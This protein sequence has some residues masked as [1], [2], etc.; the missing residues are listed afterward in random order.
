MKPMFDQLRRRLAELI[1]PMKPR[2]RFNQRHATRTNFDTSIDDVFNAVSAA[3]NGDFN[4]MVALG[5]QMLASDGHVRT[6]FAKRKLAVMGDALSIVPYDKSVAEDVV[7]ARAV[8]QWVERCDDWP[9]AVK[10][11]LEACFWPVAVVEK[12]FKENCNGMR[13]DL[14]GL[15]RVDPNLFDYQ[16]GRL[17]IKDTSEDGTIMGSAHEPDPARYVV[18]RGD[19]LCL[20]D[21]RGGLIRPLLFWHFLKEKDWGWWGQF[22]ERFG[23]PFMV[24]RVDS[25]DEDGKSTLE[26]AFGR[27]AKLFGVVVS[28]DTELELKEANTTGGGD[29]FERLHRTACEEISKIILGQFGTTQGAPAGLNSNTAEVLDSVRG[30]F[31][32]FDATQLGETSRREIF[33]QF[34]HVN[35]IPGRPPRALWGDTSSQDNETFAKRLVLYRRAGLRLTD[36][37]IQ[38]VSERENVTFAWEASSS[39]TGHESRQ[40]LAARA[41]PVT[42]PLKTAEIAN[43]RVVAAA[44]PRV[45]RALPAAGGNFALLEVPDDDPFLSAVLAAA[46]QAQ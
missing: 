27:A 36:A 4:G 3:E 20:P 35:A 46:T 5:T 26:D 29:A 41:V 17:R 24:G 15:K 2:T 45:T 12:V 8:Q 31:K 44:L 37:S 32:A 10:A 28:K 1:L 42:S 38:Q 16:E 40:A 33:R 14:V 39:E 34:L 23:A 43:A 13:F 25:E 30:D 18:H 9:E 11:L 19:P 21:Q 22:L 6:E 7:A